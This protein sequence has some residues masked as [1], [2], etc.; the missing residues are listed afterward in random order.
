MPEMLERLLN[1]L[2]LSKNQAADDVLL[3]ALRLG[4]EREQRV[5]L[6]GLMRRKTVRGLGGVIGLYANLAGAT[7][8]SPDR[9]TQTRA[10]QASP[11]QLLVLENI[12]DFYHALCE[13]GRSN[14]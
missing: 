10:T 7:P 1:S 5:A 3:E 2:I 4:N 11:L 13:C 12:R 14:D 9:S 6:D 8:A